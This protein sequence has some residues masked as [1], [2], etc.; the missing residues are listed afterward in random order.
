V[1]G[2]YP[3]GVVATSTRSRSATLGGCGPAGRAVTVTRTGRGRGGGGDRPSTASWQD[4]HPGTA[5]A[6]RRPHP[7]RTCME[8][9]LC[10]LGNG[11]SPEPTSE[12]AL[13]RPQRSPHEDLANKRA[14]GLRGRTLVGRISRVPASP[15]PGV[16]CAFA[17]PNTECAY[18]SKRPS[19]EQTPM[20]HR[21][22]RLRVVRIGPCRS[23]RARLRYSGRCH[24]PRARR[25]RSRGV[26][27]SQH[28]KAR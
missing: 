11:S 8:R 28:P 20:T 25:R 10:G 12:G 6:D 24:T 3:P 26:C 19:P 1:S 2:Q 16:R 15:M 7:G 27:R 4:G 17:P 21:R 18:A 22:S 9:P 14:R 13:R 5:M 23:V